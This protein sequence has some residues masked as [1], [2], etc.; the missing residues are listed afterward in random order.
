MNSIEIEMGT[1]E[2]QTSDVVTEFLKKSSFSTLFLKQR[3]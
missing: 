3:D 2:R 1:L